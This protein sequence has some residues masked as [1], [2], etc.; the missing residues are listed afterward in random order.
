[1]KAELTIAR[2]AADDLLAQSL[3]D[4]QWGGSPRVRSP[5]VWSFTPT[6]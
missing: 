5:G 6:R 2:S 3:N 1:M 4:A